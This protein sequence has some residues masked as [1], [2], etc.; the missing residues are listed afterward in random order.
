MSVSGNLKDINITNIIQL[1]C[2]ENNTVQVMINWRGHDASVF[3]VEG[4]IFHA[5]FKDLKG[6]KA[7]YKILRL[8]EGEFNITRPVVIPDRTIHDSWSGLLLEGARVMDESEREK[9]TIV[10]T[11]ALDLSQHPT[12]RKLAILTKSGE[13]IQNNGFDSPDRYGSFSTAFLKKSKQLA[14]A[15][16]LGEV[17]Y[18]SYAAGEDNLFFFGCGDYHVIVQMHRESDMAPLVRL[19]GELREKL[20][21]AEVETV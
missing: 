9:D 16:A 13:C 5:R 1:N 14:G 21:V 18:S 8:D 2:I 17:V 4:N 6:E 11:I 10:R 20:E 15:F 12:I 3:I 19:V 7:L